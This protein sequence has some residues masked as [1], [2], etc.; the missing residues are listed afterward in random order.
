VV[1]EKVCGN[2]KKHVVTIWDSLS[3]LRN[4]TRRNWFTFILYH[5]IEPKIFEK[6]IEYLE[7]QY[8]ITSLEYL[9][10]YYQDGSPLPKNP[11]FITFDD[12]WRSN[13]KLLPFIEKNQVPITIFLTTGFV[14]TNRKPAPITIHMKKSLEEGNIEYSLE[15]ERTMLNIEEIKEM[16]NHINFQA[17]GVNHY[18]STL[19]SEVSLKSELVES[20][21]YIEEI[22]GNPVYAFAYPYN[23]ANEK[24]AKV[25]ESCGY[26]FARV[27]GRIMNKP[28][29]NRYLL[30]CVG[31]YEKSSISE[32][33][34]ILF[35]A[36]LK[37]VL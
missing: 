14:G 15:P 9:L 37:T 23:R 32:L 28:G 2:L 34:N 7:K 10:K 3:P 33:Q 17:H 35:K 11:L 20:K 18:P 19:I 8:N 27:G 29:T 22:T 31:V 25:V 1:Y 24:V 12:G 26:V 30:N 13:Y 4:Y 6:H 5:R 16:S 36:E 21:V